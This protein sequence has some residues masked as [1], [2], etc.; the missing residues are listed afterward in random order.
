MKT[1]RPSYTELKNR[2][3]VPPMKRLAGSQLSDIE[4]VFTLDVP[5]ASS[6]FV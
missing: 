1:I 5:A 4:H 6:V 2:T 3:R